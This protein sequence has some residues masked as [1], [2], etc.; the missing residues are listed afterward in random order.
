MK[1]FKGYYSII[2]L[3]SNKFL[4]A[5][6]LYTITKVLNSCIPFFLLPIMTLYLSPE[7]YG[8]ISM[9]VVVASFVQ[10]IVT[11][12]MDS[13]IVRKY[14]DTNV[15]I[16]KYIGSCI[17]YILISVVFCTLILHFTKEKIEVIIHVPSM[18]LSLIPLYC[19]FLFFK[20]ILLYF[21]QVK[22]LPL[23]FGTFSI[24]CT[25]VEVSIALFCIIILGLNWRG[26]V[27]SLGITAFF[28]AIFAFFYFKKKQMILFALNKD[29]LRHA[30][31]YG[32]GLVPHAIGGSI[33]VLANRFYIGNMISLEE[34]GF[35]SVANQLA[36]ILSFLILSFNNAYVPW[37]FERLSNKEYDKTKLVRT[38]YIFMCGFCLLGFFSYVIIDQIFPFFINSSFENSLKHVPWLLLGFVFQ[39]FY[40]VQTNYIMFV[41]KTY[42]TGS[43]TIISATIS[44]FLNLIFIKFWGAIGASIAFA[45]TYLLYFVLTWIVSAKVFPMPWFKFKM[46][47]KKNC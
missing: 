40:F 16:P 8:L 20:N 23:K 17:I 22:S 26:R 30:I 12:N 11:L 38:T 25:I 27:V 29:Y 31:V 4:K 39:G 6:G 7:D 19:F 32:I 35:Y 33:M 44:I 10:P 34:V 45:V 46:Y 28:S 47:E 14:Y 37:L 2:N 41:E 5:F 13:S 9:V 18:V 43:I 21:W 1:M 36:C 24:C 42:L 3:C 15:D